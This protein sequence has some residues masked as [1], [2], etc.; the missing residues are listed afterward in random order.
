MI[1]DTTA[2]QDVLRL[3]TEAVARETGLRLHPGNGGA[4]DATVWLEPAN[5][6]FAVAVKRWAQHTNLGA[7]IDQI[8]RLPGNGLLVADYVNPRMADALRRHG[9][10]FL[11]TAGNAYVNQFPVYVYVT[12]NRQAALLVPAAP[13]GAHRAFEPKGLRVTYAFLCRPDLLNAPYRQ[14]ARQAGVAVGTVGWVLNGLKAAQFIRGSDAGRGRRLVNCRKL[15]DRWVE[16]YPAKLKP[17]LLLGVFVADDPHW[18]RT[19]DIRRYGGLWGGEIAAA[20]YT[21][22]LVPEIATVY[23]PEPG[24]APLLRDARLR[25]ATLETRHLGAQVLLYRPFWPTEL[26]PDNGSGPMMDLVHP[27]LAY[28]DLVATAEPRNL[29]AARILYDRYIAQHCGDD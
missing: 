7:L 2:D 12:G 4:H 26:P 11:D 10:Q 13:D 15:L 19:V 23:V 17:K 3:A 21:D 24:R 5:R 6:V 18:W 29:D 14:I 28:A 1:T 8:R 9:V 27:I 16:A 20:R 22:Y 25:K